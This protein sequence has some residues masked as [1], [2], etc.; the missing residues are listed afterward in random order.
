M[1]ICWFQ[2]CVIEWKCTV[3]TI[4]SQ[5]VTPC[6][7]VKYQQFRGTYHHHLHIYQHGKVCLR[8]HDLLNYRTDLSKIDIFR[9]LMI[10]HWWQLIPSQKL[11]LQQRLTLSFDIA[12]SIGGQGK[13]TYFMYSPWPSLEAALS[14]FKVLFLKYQLFMIR[15]SPKQI[16]QPQALESKMF[17]VY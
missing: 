10:R 4:Q 9:K 6:T 12:A 3:W 7:L 14:I 1:C 8:H 5:S 11:F 2:K 16:T 15:W 13:L 17:K